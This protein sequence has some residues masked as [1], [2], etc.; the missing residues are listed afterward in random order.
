MDLSTVMASPSYV[1]AADAYKKA[2]ATAATVTAYTVLVRP[3][4]GALGRVRRP[5]PPR[6]APEAAAYQDHLHLPVRVQRGR[7]EEQLLLERARV[8]RHPRRPGRHETALPHQLLRWPADA[9]RAARRHHH[10]RLRGRRVHLW[11]PMATSR[12]SGPP[13]P[14]MLVLTFDAENTEVAL[15]KYVPSITAAMEEARRQETALQIFINDN[16]SWEGITHQHPATF[17]TVAMDPALKQTIIADLDRFLKRKEYYRRIGKAR[18]RGYLLYG[19]PGTGKS[20]LIAA[21]ANYLRFDL[22]DLDISRVGGNRSLQKLLTA[23]PSKSILVIEDID[24]CFSAKSREGKTQR[25]KNGDGDESEDCSSLLPHLRQKLATCTTT[26]YV[27][28]I[29]ISF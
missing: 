12:S 9:L 5:R 24:C 13:E 2:V 20:S 8:P 18:K 17:D 15:T 22:Y 11:T 3:V 25:T 19:P 14:D 1:K 21:M 28:P 16:Y 10:R 23:M 6:A 26:R 7:R 29:S 27:A 4:R